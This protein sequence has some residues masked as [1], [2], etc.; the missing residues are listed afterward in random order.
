MFL[1]S[2]QH[3]AFWRALFANDQIPP[4]TRRRVR[5]RAAVAVLKIEE[6]RRKSKK[7]EE[8]RGKSTKLYR[9]IQKSPELPMAAHR[10]HVPTWQGQMGSGYGGETQ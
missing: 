1:T 2:H 7:I 5:K 10:R 6:N 8:N 3:E 9:I 4:V